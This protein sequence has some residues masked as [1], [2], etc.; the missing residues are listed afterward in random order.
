MSRFNRDY[1]EGFWSYWLE[2]ARIKPERNEL[3]ADTLC[4]VRFIAPR[5]GAA[6]LMPVEKRPQP[7][8]GLL[9]V[10]PHVFHRPPMRL[11]TTDG[12][13]LR[14]TAE[15]HRPRHCI[16]YAGQDISIHMVKGPGK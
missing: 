9:T 4:L 7:G 10:E 16:Q 8:L 5:T 14:Y 1:E 12:T 11:V 3:A 15:L 6:H 13:E 2:Y